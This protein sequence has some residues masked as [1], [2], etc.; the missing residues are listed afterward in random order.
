[1]AYNKGPDLFEI[2]TI[3][4]AILVVLSIPTTLYVRT[5]TLQA[6]IN[7][8]CKTNYNLL[9]VAVAGKDIT[10]LCRVKNQTITIK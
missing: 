8:E 3:L 1:M 10:N 5:T 6:I 9:Q 4:A 7:K 2:F